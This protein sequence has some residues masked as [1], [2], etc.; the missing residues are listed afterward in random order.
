[1]AM[2]AKQKLTSLPFPILV[3]ELCRR[4]GVVQDTERD[5]EITPSSST[6]IRC[7]EAEYTREEDDMRREATANTT[8][9]VDV[10]MLPADA[11]APTPASGPP[12]T[13]ASSSSSHDPGASSFGQPIRITQA[14]ILKMGRLA[15]TADA[16][17][18]KL[19]RSVPGMIESVIE[20][21]RDVDYLKSVDFNE[22]MKTA[23]D[24]DAPGDAQMGDAAVGDTDA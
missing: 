23:E 11:S 1:M 2:R 19:E 14:M 18:A 13:S 24:Q 20:L 10:D 9:E 3:T 8:P 7:I 4:A 21:W 22:L 12:G 16:R 5:I 6:D 17:V 15:Q